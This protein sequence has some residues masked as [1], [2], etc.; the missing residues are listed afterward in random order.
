MAKKTDQSAIAR[1]PVDSS[2]AV[3][4]EYRG[5]SFKEIV[6]DTL[7]LREL[8][9][10]EISERLNLIPGKFA[11]WKAL[12]SDVE[13]ELFRLETDYEVWYADKYIQ[14]KKRLEAEKPTETMVKNR[15]V[16]DFSDEYLSKQNSICALKSTLT[17]VEGLYRSYDI[18]SRTLVA[19]AS[20]TRAE[21]GSLMPEA[22]GRG[23]L[24]E[25][26]G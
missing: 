4:F 19:L 20:M 7:K 24:K 12:A 13:F 8:T 15:I 3:A 5:Q 17:K 2:E 6:P 11:S 16:L 14:T 21:I 9:P 18:M 10:K 25:I 23:N 22:Q 1:A 26:R